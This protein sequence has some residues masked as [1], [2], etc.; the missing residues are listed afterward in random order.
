M[1]KLNKIYEGKAKIIYATPDPHLIIAEFKDSATAF[2]GTKKATIAHKGEYNSQISVKLFELL[3]SMG[4]PTHL[5]KPLSSRELLLKKLKMIPVE[6]VVRNIVAGSLAR[7]YGKTEGEV[8]PKTI[9][10]YYLKNDD[11]HDPM[12]NADHIQVFGLATPAQVSQMHQLALKVNAV[13][14]SFFGR[15]GIDLVDFKLEF[16]VN[17]AGDMFL[18]DELSPDNCRL[19]DST[20]K[21]K[22]DKDRFRFDLGQV[23]E[24]YQEIMKRVSSKA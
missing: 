20:T 4:I 12:M 10:E 1:E 22:L 6:V 18:A 3:E 2:D 5:V 14:R 19:W 23:E 21:E 13:L 11:L 16:G 17:E 8:L 9:V 15:V 24:A 7:K